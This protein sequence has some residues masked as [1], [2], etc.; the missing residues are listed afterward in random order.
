MRAH[1]QF[2]ALLRAEMS[3]AEIFFGSLDDPALGEW[4]ALS[5]SPRDL[6]ERPRSA[7]PARFLERRAVA[8]HLVAAATGWAA[9]AVAIGHGERGAPCILQPDAGALHISLSARDAAFA[10][11]LSPGPVGV[12]IEP[13]ALESRDIPWN[14]LHPAEQAQLRRQPAA[15]L[16]QAF[17]ALWTAKEAALKAL[18]AGLALAP[19]QICIAPGRDGTFAIDSP[20]M[21]FAR[22]RGAGGGADIGGRAFVWSAV[23]LAQ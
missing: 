10:I 17:L 13:A 14:V 1:P 8:R 4:T 7:A 23:A 3:G 11:A 12:D 22:A 21:D 9:G 20:G 16:A 18:G 19:E 6:E 5:P 2:P 15:D